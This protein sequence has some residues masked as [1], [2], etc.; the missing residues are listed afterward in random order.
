MKQSCAT[1]Y[2]GLGVLIASAA[3]SYPGRGKQTKFDSSLNEEQRK[4]WKQIKMKRW[5]IFVGALIA[6]V[7]IAK[8]VKLLKK[9][10]MR[11]VASLVLINLIYMLWPKGD[12]MKNH[13][14]EAQMKL[15]KQPPS[16][17]VMYGYGALWMAGL[18]LYMYDD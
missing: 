2:A 3:Y 1:K 12:Y 16:K 11:I 8:R 7:V 18:G 10:W 17:F 13:V 15:L 5:T 14:T 4:I 6:G 9:Q